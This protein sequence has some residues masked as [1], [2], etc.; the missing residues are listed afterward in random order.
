MTRYEK[1]SESSKSL[2]PVLG[3]SLA[4]IPNHSIVWM[5]ACWEDIAVRDY[6]IIEA[7]FLQWCSRLQLTN[8]ASQKRKKRVTQTNVTKSL[9]SF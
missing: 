7:K 8:S 1:V 2:N 4:H 5:A 9:K 6:L 3:F